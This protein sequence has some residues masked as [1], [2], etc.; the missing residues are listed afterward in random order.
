MNITTKQKKL[1]SNIINNQIRII[2]ELVWFFGINSFHL[3]GNK[4][5]Y[6]LH[7]FGYKFEYY[8]KLYRL[9]GYAVLFSVHI[10]TP[11]VFPPS[12]YF[13]LS[14]HLIWT[15]THHLL[16]KSHNNNDPQNIPEF[17]MEKSHKLSSILIPLLYIPEY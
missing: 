15:N 9:N 7:I 1:V 6:I 13:S 12:L 8:S 3:K 4:T 16:I 17:Q 2:P 5:I 11:L 14:V 10:H